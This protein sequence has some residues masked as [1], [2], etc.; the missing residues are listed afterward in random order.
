MNE[1]PLTV[2]DIPMGGEGYV[3]PGALAVD[4]NGAVLINKY[5]VV[6]LTGGSRMTHLRKTR[7]GIVATVSARVQYQQLFFSRA[8]YDDFE[9]VAI[10]Q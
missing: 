1:R 4:Q 2:M 5:A 6:Y 10:V 8:Q 9:A 7:H 3:T